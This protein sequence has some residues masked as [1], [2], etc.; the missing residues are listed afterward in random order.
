MSH[1]FLLAAAGANKK[2]AGEVLLV[3]DLQLGYYGEVPVDQLI[4]G[5]SLAKMINLSQGTPIFNDQP[6]LKFA[7]LGKT[8]YV[9]KKPFR[10]SASYNAI[11]GIGAA[12]GQNIHVID[13]KSYRVRLLTGQPNGE[14]D[15]LMYRVHANGGKVP[16]FAEY[17]NSDLNMGTASGEAYYTLCQEIMSG[18]QSWRV[19]RHDV[20][21]SQTNIDVSD[22]HSYVGWRP[23]L[24]LVE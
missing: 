7:H 9:A 18:V 8:I 1:L 22:V 16:A 19:A 20:P 21:S 6:W 4:D 23:V 11:N 14:F 24:E 12:L 15:T 17:A 5:V 2:K 3:G 13:G 10:K